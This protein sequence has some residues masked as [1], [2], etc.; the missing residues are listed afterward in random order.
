V[1]QRFRC[2][3]AKHDH[4]M[5]RRHRIVS[6]DEANPELFMSPGPATNHAFLSS[7]CRPCSTNAKR[8]ASAGDSRLRGWAKRAISE[9]ALRTILME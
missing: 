7:C 1:G 3:N 8:I 4:T 6:F 2:V 9:G 5:S